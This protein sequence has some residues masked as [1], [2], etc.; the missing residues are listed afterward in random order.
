MSPANEMNSQRPLPGIDFNSFYTSIRS[1]DRRVL[2]FSL[3]A[4]TRQAPRQVR[5]TTASGTRSQDSMR[6]SLYR[7]S[8]FLVLAVFFLFLPAVH[9]K[10]RKPKTPPPA[11]QDTIEVVGHITVG[12]VSR[13]LPTRH[14]SRY[15]LYA[16]RDGGKNIT[17]ID[18]TKASQPSVLADMSYASSG[19]SQ[20]KIV[21]VAGTAALVSS[22]T[23]SPET[24]PQAVRI[25]DFSDP[26]S[27]KVAR[28]FTG[29]TAISRDDRRGLIFIADADGIWIL[30]QNLAED[31]E[32]EKTYADY[33]LY[34]H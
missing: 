20:S 15:Y 6:N 27:P 26:Q 24:V 14:Y 17:L 13:F 7:W 23:A 34:N 1:G 10:N 18:V 9:G 33:V 32:V 21:V 2:E 8:F 19:S 5:T 25:M 29:I 11:P 4:S 16:E 30:Q 3:A 22:E 12:H 28:E 31:P